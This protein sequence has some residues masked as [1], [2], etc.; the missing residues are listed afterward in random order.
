MYTIEDISRAFNGLEPVRSSGR[1][2]S[3]VSIDS[4]TIAEGEIFFCIRGDNHDGHQFIGK[5]ITAGA[6]MVVVD[7]QGMAI[8]RSLAIAEIS[9]W[10]V[11]DTTQALQQLAAFQRKRIQGKLFGVTGS[12]GKTTTR[13]MIFSLVE[14]I[15]KK[16]SRRA[17][18]ATTGNLNNHWGLPLIL[19]RAHLA[20]DPVILEMGMNHPGEIANLTRIAKPELAIITSVSDAH[21]EFFGSVMEI[22]AAKLE[23]LEGMASNAQL[24]YCITSEGIDQAIEKARVHNVR[25]TLF[26]AG[27]RALDIARSRSNFFSMAGVELVICKIDHAM[28]GKGVAFDWMGH[29]IENRNFFGEPMASNLCGALTLLAKAG[30]SHQELCAAAAEIAP[31]TRRRFQLFRKTAANR[32]DV[33]VDDSYNANPDSF[34]AAIR[35]S[36]LLAGGGRVA[37]VAGEMAELGDQFALEAHRQLGSLCGSLGVDR[38]LLSGGKYMDAWLDG[39]RLAGGGG[40]VGKIFVATEML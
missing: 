19:C 31:L 12:S 8:A 35:N 3:G 15:H 40:S 11:D 32:V 22:A 4:R 6:S 10:M 33:L 9:L 16:Q 24:L 5:A 37:V 1:P 27:D 36:M 39:Y 21:R 7:R 28:N 20:S 25:L 29:Q 38:I 23:I 18:Y 34:E 26:G 30:Y 2:A 13:D 14:I 17:P